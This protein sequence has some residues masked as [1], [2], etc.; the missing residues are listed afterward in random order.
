MFNTAGPLRI[1]QYIYLIVLYCYTELSHVDTSSREM[2]CVHLETFASTVMVGS[3]SSQI[4]CNIFVLLLALPD[5]T[6][7]EV[8]LRLYKNAENE[9]KLLTEN[10]L[11]GTNVCADKLHYHTLKHH[12]RS[13]E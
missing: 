6:Q 5:G 1:S 11:V 4:I 12:S 8:D 2:E 10:K 9:T 3:S 7:A 13:F